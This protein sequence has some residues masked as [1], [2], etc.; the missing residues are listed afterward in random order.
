MHGTLRKTENVSVFHVCKGQRSFGI[1]GKGHRKHFP[2][3][4]KKPSLG[5]AELVWFIT[6][7]LALDKALH[8]LPRWHSCCCKSFQ[9]CLTLATLRTTARQAAL[10]MGLSRQEY[11]SEFPGPPPGDL[12]NPGIN[13][14]LPLVVKNLPA[15]DRDIKRQVQSLSWEDPLEEAMETHSSILAWRIHGQRRPAG[16]G[17]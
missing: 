14:H 10:S 15:N 4:P 17:P 2:C 11:W 13:Y 8:G 12:P 6:T 7:H 9:W 3:P 5:A 16:Y 1:K